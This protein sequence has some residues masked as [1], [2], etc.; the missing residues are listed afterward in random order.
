MDGPAAAAKGLPVFVTHDKFMKVMS[1]G[2]VKIVAGWYHSLPRGSGCPNWPNNRE[3]LVWRGDRMSLQINKNIGQKWYRLRLSQQKC[4]ARGSGVVSG[5]VV[6]NLDSSIF[7]CVAKMAN[8]T[9]CSPPLRSGQSSWDGDGRD[10]LQKKH[11]HSG[12]KGGGF[13]EGVAGDEN[14]ARLSPRC[15]GTR[16][17]SDT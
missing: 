5:G 1:H 4:Q 14:H 11:T 3:A 9:H 8:I 12:R 7:L 16:P 6:F 13:S 2:G 15:F 17:S 10:K